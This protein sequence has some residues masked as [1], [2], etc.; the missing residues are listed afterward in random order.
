M[1]RRAL[2]TGVTGQDGAYLS[3]VLLENGYQVFGGHRRSASEGTARLRE[4]GIDADV[5]MVAMDLLEITNILRVLERTAPDEVYNLAAQSFVALSFEQPVHTSEVDAL[6]VTRLLESIRAVCP[7]TRF[8]QASTSE[9]FGKVR[10]TP[11]SERTPF[12]PRS[13]YGVSKL[14][15][16]W[17]TVNY[18][19]AYGL[20]ATSG[21]LFN[22]ESPLRGQEFVTRKIT[23]SLARIRYG[24]QEVLELG[25]LEASRDWGYAGDYVWGMYQM[26]QQPEPGDYVLATGR[27]HTVREF[28]DAAAG[29]A[30]FRL[31]WEGEGEQ[32]Q[33]IDLESEQV[34]VRVN[35]AL[36]RPAEV[37]ILVGDAS[38]ARE[39]LQ[40]APR[41]TF[42][43]LV[44]AMMEADL[45]RE[46]SDA[47]DAGS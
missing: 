31:R 43:D 21:I 19:E 42:D 24:R 13:P 46:T 18:R 40:W 12:Y 10:E 3:R 5:E 44:A 39:T 22:H 29:A 17:M 15:A 45:R 35:P 11:Q 4:L 34:I 38:K 33:A 32:A 8:Y 26:L 20:H 37:D 2:I 6:G 36:Y 14:Y 7:Q 16:H 9:M 23:S 1:T 30:G 25:N 47:P 27:T 41:L 28:V